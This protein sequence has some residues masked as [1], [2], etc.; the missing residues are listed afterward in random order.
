MHRRGSV[1]GRNNGAYRF[2]GTHRIR[3]GGYV[4]PEEARFMGKGIDF[5]LSMFDFDKTSVEEVRRIF[6]ATQTDPSIQRVR[7]RIWPH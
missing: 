1:H 5:A 7:Q 3:K 4:L 6:P 2:C